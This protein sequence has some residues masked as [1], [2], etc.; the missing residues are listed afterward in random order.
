MVNI[1]IKVSSITKERFSYLDADIV[2]NNNPINY[3]SNNTLNIENYF[4]IKLS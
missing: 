4:G 3:P 2:D 1:S